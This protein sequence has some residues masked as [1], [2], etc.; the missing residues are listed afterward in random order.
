[1]ESYQEDVT[2]SDKFLKSSGRL[3]R[4]RYLKRSLILFVV[5]VILLTVIAVVCMEPSG[6]DISSAGYVLF[7]LTIVVFL[8]VY[9][10]LTIR[11]L[12]DLD[13]SGWFCLA[14]LVPVVNTLFSIYVV[15]APGTVGSNKY[16]A[17]PLEGRR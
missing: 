9:Y 1:M 2:L 12:H 15:F 11:R 4:L 7:T 14:M 10:L 17:D 8:P 13:K 3:N 16:G 5:E 6:N